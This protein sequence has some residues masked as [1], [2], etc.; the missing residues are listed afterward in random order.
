MLDYIETSLQAILDTLTTT[1]KKVGIVSINAEERKFNT[2][3]EK[4]QITIT[5]RDLPNT[6]P[7][8]PTGDKIISGNFVVYAVESEKETIKT[9]FDTFFAQYNGTKNGDYIYNFTT[10]VPVGQADN[11]GEIDFQIWTFGIVAR[12]IGNILNIFD[13]T[14]TIG[15]NVITAS[16]GLD[17]FNFA[18]QP[19][20]AEYPISSVGQQKFRYYK[21][22]LQFVCLDTVDTAV[23]ALRNLIYDTTTNIVSVTVSSKTG[24]ITFNGAIKNAQETMNRTNFPALLFTIER[25]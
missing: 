13:V 18:K 14:L 17:T 1:L 2:F 4:E 10:L 9:L 21:W 12:Y 16:K 23:T 19:V 24:T 6:L 15:G 22:V 3:E 5:Y 20:F 7:N 8:F 25:A 11:V